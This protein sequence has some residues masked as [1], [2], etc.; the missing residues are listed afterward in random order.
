MSE[1]TP[2]D[3]WALGN[4][5][6]PYVGRWSRVVAAEFLKW[7]DVPV[8]KEWLDVGCGTGALSQTIL[9]LVDPKSV[10][11]IDRSDGFVAYARAQTP[12]ARATFETGDATALPVETGAYDVAV[13]GLVLN[14]VPQPEQMVAEMA[15]AVR[16]DGIVGV[17]VWD[18][19][20][21]MELMQRF[22]EAA[23]ALDPKALELDE[24][25][26]FPICQPEPLRELFEKAG[27]RDVEVRSI[28]IATVFKD[29]ED[30]W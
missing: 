10:K 8:G 14:F 30:Y 21:K 18:Y 5:Y 26:R 22:W 7:L 13:S 25:R 20:G 1:N 27:L 15:R 3:R 17:Y 11:G 23:E 4:A 24:G 28:E 16:P 6:E 19:A 29:F 12:D 2:A 9:K